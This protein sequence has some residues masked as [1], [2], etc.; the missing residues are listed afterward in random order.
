MEK[1]TDRKI[2][3]KPDCRSIESYFNQ[4]ISRSRLDCLKA[5]LKRSQTQALYDAFEQQLH[6]YCRTEASSRWGV[7]FGCVSGKMRSKTRSLCRLPT[8]VLV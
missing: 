6:I 2:P 1:P 3:S 7:F 4:H 5:T 8:R